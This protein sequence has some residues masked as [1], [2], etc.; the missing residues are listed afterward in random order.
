MAKLAKSLGRDWP[1]LESITVASAAGGTGADLVDAAIFRVPDLKNSFNPP[2]AYNEGVFG[3]LANNRMQVREAVLVSNGSAN[4]AG[5]ATNN[6]TFRLNVWRAGVLQGCIASYS[7]A[8]AGLTLGTAVAAGDLGTAKTVTPSAMTGIVEGMALG[9]DSSTSFEVVIATKVTA[10]TFTAIFTKTHATNAAVT[11]VLVPMLGIPMVLAKAAKTDSG[12]STVGSAGAATITPT[13]ML[14]IH[15]GDTLQVDSGGSQEL[16]VVTAVAA[17]TFTATFA[18]TH[19]AGFAIVTSK[20]A[21]QA[22]GSYGF[23]LQPGDV[24]SY[25]RIS[26]N[27]TGLA[28]PALQVLLD[29]VPTGISQ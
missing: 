11:S 13:S 24:V 21:N 4:T 20:L 27:V 7:M 22:P 29:L 1:Q 10:T 16:V 8:V 14:G 12:S 25:Q 15:V 19:S 9:V 2:G 28:T 6:A 23:D 17:T 26:N 18:N 5:N 3:A